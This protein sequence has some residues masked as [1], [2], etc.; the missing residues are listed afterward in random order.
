MNPLLFPPL[1]S[2]TT[3]NAHREIF[4]AQLENIQA[5]KREKKKS[6]GKGSINPLEQGTSNKSSPEEAEPVPG[7]GAGASGGHFPKDWRGKGC[8][9]HPPG[10]C[11]LE[12]RS[13]KQL[14]REGLHQAGKERLGGLN[15]CTGKTQR[16]LER[17]FCNLHHPMENKTG[18]IWVD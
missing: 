18:R 10:H 4:S 5:G 17:S 1:T 9:E 7:T 6:L 3:P 8:L 11:S 13:W 2:P 12:G 16:T 15:H 14:R